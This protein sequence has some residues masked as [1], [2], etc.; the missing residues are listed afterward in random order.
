MLEP[1]STRPRWSIG[2][3][4]GAVAV[5]AVMLSIPATFGPSGSV[6]LGFLLG[7]TGAAIIPAMLVCK[8]QAQIPSRNDARAAWLL[9]QTALVFSV[10]AWAILAK[11]GDIG[12]GGGE[13][14][15]LATFVTGYIAHLMAAV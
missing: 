3:M 8:V 13:V 7:A 15:V 9:A 14:I 12:Q 5:V 2:R 11:Y 10:L 1:T 4:M 6:V